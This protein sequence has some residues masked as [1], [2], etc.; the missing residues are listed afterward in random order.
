[1]KWDKLERTLLDAARWNT[2]SDRV[3][4]TFEQRVMAR[5]RFTPV[6]PWG[7][8][9]QALWRAAAP[10]VAIMLLLSAWSFYPGPAAG[11][12]DDL[13]LALENTVLAAVDQDSVDTTW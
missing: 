5:L 4:Y 12:G 6:D 13:G 1:M 10:C 9:S 11:E 2:P 3:P 8:W 7:E